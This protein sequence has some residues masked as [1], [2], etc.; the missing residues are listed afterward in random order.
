MSKRV[1]AVSQKKAKKP[2]NKKKLLT[3]LICTFLAAVILFGAVL[4]IISVVKSRNAVISYEG[5]TMD[6]KV[7]SFFVGRF[8]TKY[9]RDLR[10]DGYP[11]VNTEEFW[12]SKYDSEKTHGEIMKEFATLQ[13]KQIIINNY[14]FDRYSSLTSEDEYKIEKAIE[15]T[16]EYHTGGSRDEFD[17]QAAEYGFDYDAYC[18]AVEM[19][20]KSERAFSAI[21]GTDGSAISGDKTSCNN[22]LSEYSHVSLIFIRTE[23]KLVIHDDKTSMVVPL[24]EEEKAQRQA[25][26]EE[27]STAITAYEQGG[28][29]QMTPSAYALYLS[30]YGEGDSDYNSLGYYFHKDSEFTAEYATQFS[31]VT[32]K[33]LS[34]EI[35][36]YAKVEVDMRNVHDENAESS[37]GVCF[38]YKSAPQSGAY[39]ESVLSGCFSDFYSDASTAFFLDASESLAELIEIGP[40]FSDVDFYAISTNSILYPRYDE[41]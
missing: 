35:G 9:I 7:A 20:Y 40:K 36:S 8:K 15:E 24:S 2:I 1:E 21:Y 18:D 28:E 11:A 19:L 13:L 34:M 25:A 6:E 4:G 41:K 23:D 14:L 29:G 32:E 38:I 26:I 16:L 33:A 37:P 10:S 30:K 39:S 31:A 27:I 12:N 22:Y 3:I 5:I 17:L